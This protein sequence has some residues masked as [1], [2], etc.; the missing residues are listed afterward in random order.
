MPV[1]ASFIVA[2]ALRDLRRSLDPIARKVDPSNRGN[3]VADLLLTAMGWKFGKMV[4]SGS[5]ANKN[6]AAAWI[7]RNLS[8]SAIPHMY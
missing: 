5:F 3:S 2:W 8:E 6:E 7:E 1:P 4:N